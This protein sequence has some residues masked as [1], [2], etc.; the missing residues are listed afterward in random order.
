MNADK[1]KVN[2]PGRIKWCRC[3][4]HNITETVESVSAH[5]VLSALPATADI[6][7]K[8]NN[9]RSLIHHYEQDMIA[10]WMNQNVRNTLL[11]TSGAIC[12]I[13]Y[14]ISCRHLPL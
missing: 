13:A 8:Y 3:L 9:V 14:Y 11:K 5:P 1:Q 7:R 6:L 12:K 4:M 10:I 2:G